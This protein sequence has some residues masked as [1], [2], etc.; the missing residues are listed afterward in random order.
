MTAFL[1]RARAAAASAFALGFAAVGPAAAH[2]DLHRSEPADGAV[3]RAPPPAVVLAFQEPVR[4]TSLRL[5]DGAGRETKLAR[6]GE[7]IAATREVR[8]GVQGPLTPGDYRIEWRGSS[9]DGHVGGG[10][11]RFRVEPTR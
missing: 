6:E 5:L 9:V 8:A 10:T 2:S 11:V 7:R 1:R 3:L 4:V